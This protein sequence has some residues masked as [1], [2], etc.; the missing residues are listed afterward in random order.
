MGRVLHA[1]KIENSPNNFESGRS[2]DDSGEIVQL[3]EIINQVG[4]QWIKNTKEALKDFD[5][6]PRLKRKS[7]KLC[8]FLQF[9]KDA[10]SEQA[11]G[12]YARARFYN[13]QAAF[14][15]EDIKTATRISVLHACSPDHREL[16]I[17]IRKAALRT[18]RATEI[19]PREAMIENAQ[20]D[21]E[22]AIQNYATLLLTHSIDSEQVVK[23]SW[24]VSHYKAVRAQRRRRLN[25]VK[26][27]K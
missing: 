1:I 9:S 4:K 27:R 26:G 20:K 21:Y 10:L 8:F 17:E 3:Q 18:I 5:T 15:S 22:R 23:A 25:E 6:R 2:P 13:K 11:L 24:W 19:A 16:M 12:R 7:C 14:Y